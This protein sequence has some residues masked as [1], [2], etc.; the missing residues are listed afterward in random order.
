[1]ST[2]QVNCNH[3]DTIITFE[4]DFK[5]N[6]TLQC[7]RCKECSDRYQILIPDF[8]NGNVSLS[9]N[10]LPP[11][12][13]AEKY[14]VQFSYDQKEDD[15]KED[16]FCLLQIALEDITF[17]IFYLYINRFD[18]EEYGLVIFSDIEVYVNKSYKKNQ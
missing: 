18:V 1:M 3:C 17:P 2:L 4:W 11:P 14:Y 10:N 13:F 5:N 6:L 9:K 16:D 7:S 15:Q 8:E 12:S